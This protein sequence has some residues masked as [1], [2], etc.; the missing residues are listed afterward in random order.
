MHVAR[1]LGQVAWLQKAAL[2]SKHTPFE[3][4]LYGIKTPARSPDPRAAMYR[5]RRWWSIHTFLTYH[6][7]LHTNLNN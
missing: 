2:A 5:E 6:P 7:A 4:Q 3:T 1:T